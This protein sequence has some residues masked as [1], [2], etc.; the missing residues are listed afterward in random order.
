M[1]DRKEIDDKDGDWPADEEVKNGQGNA[2]KQHI[3]VEYVQ[4]RVVDHDHAKDK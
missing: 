2:E 1:I 3:L 4:E